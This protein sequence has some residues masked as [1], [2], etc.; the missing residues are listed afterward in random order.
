MKDSW[1]DIPFALVAGAAALLFAGDSEFRALV[2]R[3]ESQYSARRVSVPVLG[4]ANGFLKL[5][6]PAG[7]RRV[8]LAIFEDLRERDGA[9]FHGLIAQELGPAW[10]PLVRTRSRG[11]DEWTAVYVKQSGKNVY[12]LTATLAPGEATLVQAK[13]NPETLARWLQK[14]ERIGRCGPKLGQGG[15]NGCAY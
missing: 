10:K 11:D 6:H 8:E 1:I 5:F 14:P 3:I 9:R 15:E 12:L 7:A 2:D 4:V 13:V